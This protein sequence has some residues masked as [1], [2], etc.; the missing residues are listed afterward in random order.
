MESDSAAPGEK[1]EFLGVR[2]NRVTALLVGLLS[3]ASVFLTGILK[4]TL[5]FISDS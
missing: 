2:E 4:V 1:P 5:W 3:G